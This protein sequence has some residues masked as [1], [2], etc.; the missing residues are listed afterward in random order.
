MRIIIVGC[1]KVGRTLTEQ[2][3][4]ENHDVTVIDTNPQV[5]QDVTNNFDVMGVVGNGA[6]YLVQMD[7]GVE[8]A[9][10]LISVTA[11]DELNLLCCLFAKKPAT[12][13]RSHVC[14]IRFTAMKSILS[15]RNS[16]FR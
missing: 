9:D 4:S 7:A 6:S 8:D 16:V 12:V 5:V 14:A 10:L 15:K 13:K 3:S 11:S 2:L 1:G